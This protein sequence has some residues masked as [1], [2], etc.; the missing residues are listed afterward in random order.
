MS[1][2]EEEKAAHEDGKHVK[3]T[4]V[5]GGT[6]ETKET[7]VEADDTAGQVFELVLQRF[8]QQKSDQDAF[9]VN[10]TDFPRSRFGETVKSL[11]K[12]FG[13]ELVFEVIP[14]TSGA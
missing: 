4:L 14:P 12:H 2:I 11:L 5:W 1:V 10:G 3:V 7:E 8:H 9:E 6:G 13:K